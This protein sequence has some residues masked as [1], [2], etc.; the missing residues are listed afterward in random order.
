MI[1]LKKGCMRLLAGTLLF[2]LVSCMDQLTPEEPAD[3]FD[4][5]VMLIHLADE[6]IVPAYQDLVASLSS[7]KVNVIAFEHEKTVDN[8]NQ[9]KA[10]FELAYHDFQRVSLFE[11]GPAANLG[12][13]AAVNRF[14][15][16][17]SQMEANFTKTDVNLGTG[18]N[19]GAKGFPAMEYILYFYGNEMVT[20][21]NEASTLAKISYLMQVLVD[22]ETIATSIYQE[23]TNSYAAT[24]IAAD[25]SDVGSSLG[26]LTNAFSMALEQIKNVKLGIPLGKQT[27]NNPRV[28]LVEGKYANISAQLA[29]TQTQSLYDFYLGKTTT[30]INGIGF[31]DYVL[32][33]NA[34]SN[35]QNLHAQIT[36]GF[37]LALSQLDAISDP[38][39]KTILT[40]DSSVQAAY[41]TFQSTLIRLIKVDMSSAFGVQISY[42]DN[43]GD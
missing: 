3:D 39:A 19:V 6:V 14:P 12:F 24:F 11:I 40:D 26:K 16:D 23:W 43:D 13:D 32:H 18:E 29:L 7:F 17:T 8:L 34:A 5:T 1:D 38:M 20:Y 25:G 9:A 27:L 22:V 42:V 30:G 15:A 36:A 31:D 28:D 41:T 10:S 33:L 4:K 37:E 2:G 21:P 35:G